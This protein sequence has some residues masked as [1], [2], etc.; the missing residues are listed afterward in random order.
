MRALSEKHHILRWN[1]LKKWRFSPNFRGFSPKIRSF[2]LKNANISKIY[3]LLGFLSY[4]PNLVCYTSLGVVQTLRG[5]FQNF[6]ILT[7]FWPPKCEKWPKWVKIRK[8]R[9]SRAPK[10]VKSAK[11]PTKRLYNLKRGPTYWKIRFIAQKTWE[12]IDFW[13]ICILSSG[14]PDFSEN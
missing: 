6:A 10:R 14:R 5:N 3:L 1:T 11:I 7:H 9:R 12:K 4:K 8:I 13:D 2:E